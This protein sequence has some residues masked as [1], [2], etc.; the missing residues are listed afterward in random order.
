MNSNAIND[1]STY[2]PENP[3]VATLRN[4]TRLLTNRQLV[5][6]RARFLDQQLLVWGAT[7]TMKIGEIYEP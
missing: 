4:T 5:V 6:R 3:H 7:D 1:I 2:I